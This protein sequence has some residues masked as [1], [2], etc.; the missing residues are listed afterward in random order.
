MNRDV[1][2]KILFILLPIIAVAGLLI[3]FFASISAGVVPADF[4]AA[5]GQAAGVSQDIVN[6]TGDT[7]SKIEQIGKIQSSGTADQILNLIDDARSTNKAAYDKAFDLSHDLQEM[8]GSLNDVRQPRQQ[9]GYEA[10]ALELSL[11]SEF[12]SYTSSLN[13]FMDII[14]KAAT[15]G[16]Q[17]SQ[18]AVDDA[19]KDI[20]QKAVMINTLNQNFIDK[21]AAFDKAS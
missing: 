12:I 9:L 3:Y 15:N 19:V 6:L 4:T 10:V 7:A 8:A 11:V 14:S 20:N 1:L 18:K 17:Y 5:R 13:N 2:R 16:N 21:M